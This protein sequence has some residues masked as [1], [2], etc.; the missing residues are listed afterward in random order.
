MEIKFISVYLYLGLILRYSYRIGV[1]P[2]ERD[3]SK[4]EAPALEPDL[5]RLQ[6]ALSTTPVLVWEWDLATNRI[7]SLIDPFGMMAAISDEEPFQRVY[8][9]DLQRVLEWVTGIIAGERVGA[10]D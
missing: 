4:T 5:Q 6:L 9:D 10:I 8:P 1:L 2:V 3:T 7:S